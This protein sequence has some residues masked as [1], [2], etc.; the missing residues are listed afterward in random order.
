MIKG[1][2][3]YEEPRLGVVQ[4]SGRS[5]LLAESDTGGASGG[6]P[7]SETTAPGFAGWLRPMG[8]GT[9]Q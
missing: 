3:S 8:T 1:K 6:G 7:G 5:Q 2:K 9:L 4:L